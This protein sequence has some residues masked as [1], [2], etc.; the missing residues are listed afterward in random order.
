MKTGSQFAWLFA[1]CLLLSGAALARDPNSMCSAGEGKSARM[2][3]NRYLLRVAPAPGKRTTCTLDLV[4]PDGGIIFSRDENSFRWNSASGKDINGDGNPD[5]VVEAYT[6]GAHCC[7]KYWIFSLTPDPMLV[8]HLNNDE[9]VSFGFDARGRLVL[10]TVDEAFLG[11]DGLP[12]ADSPRAQL[13]FMLSGEEFKDVTAD[14]IT[15]TTIQA[16]RK[17]LEMLPTERFR[18]LNATQDIGPELAQVKEG[19]LNLV[20]ALWNA[21]RENDAWKALEESWP[22]SDVQRIKQAMVAAREKG[23]RKAVADWNLD[24]LAE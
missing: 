21:G 22:P 9:P 2:P 24:H 6:G 7:W 13:F 8:G 19:V 10:H 17:R 11:F 18:Q 5:V 20:L 23:T 14:F 16:L 1:A 12:Y 3:P 15:D 4:A